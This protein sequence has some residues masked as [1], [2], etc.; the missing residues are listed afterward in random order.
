MSKKGP[1]VSV[2]H[3]N[4]HLGYSRIACYQECPQKYKYSYIDG[5]RSETGVALRRGSAYHSALEFILSYKIENKEL[6]SLERAEKA[7]IRS[8][9]TE[10]LPEIEIYKVIDAVRFYYKELYPV[11][12]PIAVEQNFTTI[13]G[14]I[15]LT[16][17]VDLL[18][19]KNNKLWVVDAKFSYD[20]WAEPRAKYGCQPLL[21][22]WASL[23]TFCKQYNLEYGGFS[24]QIIR[25]F[26]TPLIQ[27]INIE[28]ISQQDSDWYE[29]QLTKIAASINAGLFPA[30]AAEKSCQWCPH[31]TLCKP[32]VWSIKTK[33]IGDDLDTFDDGAI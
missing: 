5:I 33:D 26:P 19:I 21:Y 4:D 2:H 32:A 17:R 12:N 15:K 18:H 27:E 1:I 24:Y 13:R 28:P 16:G 10:N 9:K 25:L 8:G 29:T 23:D 7:A 31:K 20:K 3:T 22:Q 6:I 30:I 14:G 11:V